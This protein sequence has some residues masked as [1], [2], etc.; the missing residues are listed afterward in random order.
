MEL[1]VVD[2]SLSLLYNKE[3]QKCQDSILRI[4]I[5]ILINIINKKKIHLLYHLVAT[6]Q[7]V[8]KNQ[9]LS[10][11]IRKNSS[12]KLKE[13]LKYLYFRD[14]LLLKEILAPLDKVYKKMN[15][16]QKNLGPVLKMENLLLGI[17]KLSLYGME[18]TLQ[19]NIRNNLEII[20]KML[21]MYH[22]H[23][24]LTQ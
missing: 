23:H 2:I 7:F 21:L 20:I 10:Q 14:Y 19:E 15:Q 11:R 24:S 6:L 4:N 18:I 12:K 16:W 5:L 22:K 1:V 8:T 3:Q 17:K 9:Y 13:H